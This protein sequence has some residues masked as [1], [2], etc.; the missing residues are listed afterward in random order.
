MPP[1]LALVTVNEIVVLCEPEAAVP[2]TVSVY[3][4]A[5]AAEVVAIVNVELPLPVI[6][7][8]ENEPVTPLGAPESASA[9]D[10]A[11]P[12][13]IAVVI[14]LDVELPAVTETLVGFAA[15]E[16]SFVVVPLVTVSAYVVV[17]LPDAAV[18]VTVSVYVPAAAEVVVE[19]D[20]VALLPDVTEVG[21]I[22]A[23]TP[24]GAPE[25][26]SETDCAEPDVVAVAIVAEVELPAVT[27]P[28]PGLAEIEKSLPKL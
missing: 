13:V 14:V 20:S 12:E 4:P 18:P 25:T 16:K 1:E 6:D 28:L 22:D 15:I 5:A 23:V 26:D 19:I 24:A 3:V 8:G 2:V 7:D 9:T 10:W 21:L 11:L 17:W 27:E